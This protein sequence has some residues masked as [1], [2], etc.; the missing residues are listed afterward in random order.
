MLRSDV[1]ALLGQASMQQRLERAVGSERTSVDRMIDRLRDRARSHRHFAL[2]YF[3]LIVLSLAIGACLFLFAGSITA[4]DGAA[5][6]ELLRWEAAFQEK[7][8]E[9]L[10][11]RGGAREPRLVRVLRCKTDRGSTSTGVYHPAAPGREGRRHPASS[12]KGLRC[13][14]DSQFMA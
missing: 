9:K 1:R 6:R 10:V 11:A 4:R 2:A 13:L 14:T 7:H 3:L 12:T 8:V 5:L